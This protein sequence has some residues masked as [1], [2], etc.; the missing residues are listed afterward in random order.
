M[1]VAL[2]DVFENCRGEKIL[3]LW[4]MKEIHSVRKLLQKLSVLA[5]HAQTSIYVLIE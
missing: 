3:V 5:P 4:H 1:D 2:L